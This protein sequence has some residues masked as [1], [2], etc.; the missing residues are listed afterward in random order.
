[1]EEMKEYLKQF[2]EEMPQWLANYNPGDQVSFSDFMS[3][4]V[5]YYPGSFV[6]GTLIKVGNQAQ[7]VHAFLQVDYQLRKETIIALLER[8]Q[9]IRGYHSIGRVEWT[10]HDLTPH[11]QYA[12][13]V[14]Y[15]PHCDPKSFV[16]QTVEPY[17]FMEIMERDADRDDSWGAERIALAFLFADGIATYYQLFCKEYR[18]APWLF[19]LQDHGFGCNYDKFGKGGLLDAI[20]ERNQCRPEYVICATN[21]DIWDGYSKVPEVDPVFGGMH[22]HERFLYKK[23]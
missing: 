9:E 8:P 1:M 15:R 13:N 20:I 12:F 19:L 18:T 2:R 14:N 6:D 7:C 3:G 4:R 11:G 16:D 5:G 21:T 10:E 22:N 23:S 17:C